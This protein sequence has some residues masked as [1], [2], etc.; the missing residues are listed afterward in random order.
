MK[1]LIVLFAISVATVPVRLYKDGADQMPY[2]LFVPDHY[3]EHN[4]Y[5]LILWLHGTG[6][7]GDDNLQNISG[8]Q[9]PGTRLWTKKKNQ[10]VHPTFVL[11]PQSPVGW[12]SAGDVKLRPEL[13]MVLGIL[14]EVRAKFHIDPNRMYILG[15]SN[16]GVGA[17]ALITTNPHLFAAAIF[18]CSAGAFPSR[19]ES[20]VD[21]P[22]W[23]FQGSKDYGLVD[24]TREMIAAIQNAGGNPRYTEYPGAGHDIWNRVF[25]EPQIVDW[26]YAKHN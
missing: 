2:R 23:A 16:G 22:I 7:I 1:W 5:P 14:N 17:W 24:S 15:Q 9:I 26:L 3:D 13:K 25:K 18:V 12:G 21:L 10:A 6:G 11:V 19:A 4:E 20:I 8:D